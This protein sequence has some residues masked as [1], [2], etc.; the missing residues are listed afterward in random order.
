MSKQFGRFMVC[1]IALILTGSSL[2]WAQFGLGK[3]KDKEGEKPVKPVQASDKAPELSDGDKKK[4]SE[5]EQR[6]EI[7]DE[8][9]AA[10]QDQK[11]SD[12]EF[13]YQVNNS[14]TFAN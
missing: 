4:L 9:E 5:I 2:T 11:S 3:H 14:I 7:K 8:I 6:P 10:W 13:A 1:F 12:L